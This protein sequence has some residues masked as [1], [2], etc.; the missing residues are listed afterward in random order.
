MEVPV[1]KAKG[2]A[3][4]KG[5]TD[6]SRGEGRLCV[7]VGCRGLTWANVRNANLESML[8]PE[9]FPDVGHCS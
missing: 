4:L 2:E 3:T 1:S 8:M 7:P 9:A 5:V 6:S